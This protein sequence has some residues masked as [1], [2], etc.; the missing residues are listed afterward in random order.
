MNPITINIF[1]ILAYLT[2]CNVHFWYAYLPEGLRE[3]DGWCNDPVDI[4]FDSG[5]NA[6]TSSAQITSNAPNT[7]GGP[8][9]SWKYNLTNIWFFY[10]KSTYITQYFIY[11]FIYT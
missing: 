5:I 1:G 6:A 4:V 11:V 3:V 10:L 9:T 2:T 8:G 7:N